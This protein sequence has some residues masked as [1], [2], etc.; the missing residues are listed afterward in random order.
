P[1]GGST[2]VGT[3]GYMAPEQFQGRASPKSDVYGLGATAL[4]MLTGMEP[5]DLP[6]EGLGIDVRRAAPPGTPAGLVRALSAMLIPD[7]DRRID[8]VDD[9]LAF[10]R[11]APEPEPRKSVAPAKPDRKQRR[12]L[13]AQEK[14]EAR[15]RRRRGRELARARRAP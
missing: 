12:E 13:R 11:A 5:E 1:A 10:V 8:S 4:A 3:F 14:R 2:V 7:P 9:A 15:E 6:H